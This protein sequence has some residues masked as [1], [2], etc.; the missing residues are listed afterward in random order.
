VA[1]ALAF[2]WHG[3]IAVEKATITKVI[4]ALFVVSGYRRVSRPLRR[5]RLDSGCLQGPY[6]DSWAT[7]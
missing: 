5:I 2:R 6:Q 1:V 7:L 4:M 3:P